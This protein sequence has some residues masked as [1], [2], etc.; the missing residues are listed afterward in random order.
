MKERRSRIALKKIAGIARSI[1][2]CRVSSKEQ[3]SNNSLVRQNASVYDEA[4]KLN[5]EIPNDDYVWS[6]SVSGKRGTNTR[7]RDLQEMIAFC[8]KDKSVKFLIIDEPDRFMR[9]IDEAFYFEIVF[10]EIGVKVWYMDPELNGDNLQSKMLRFMKYFGAESSNEE[11]I[12]KSVNGHIKALAE[13][14]YTFRTKPG[15]VKG[16]KADGRHEPHPVTW[17]YYKSALTRIAAGLSSVKETMDD[18]HQT[19]P[20]ILDRA[21][22]PYTFDEWKKLVTDP[23]YAGIVEMNKQVKFRNEN[24]LHKAMVTKAQHERILEIVNGVKKK[25]N[26]PRKGGNPKYPLNAVGVCDNCVNS[27]H[28]FKFTGSNHTNGKT[29][30]IYEDYRCRGCGRVIKRSDF[31]EKVEQRF[32]GIDMTDEGRKELMAALEF[33][34]AAEGEEMKREVARV[35]GRKKALEDDNTAHV[36]SLADP[37]V[38]SVRTNIVAAIERNNEE[39]KN[40]NGQLSGLDDTLAGEKKRFMEFALVFADQLGRQFLSLSLKNI[41]VCKQ[42]IFPAGFWVGKNLEV[43]TPEISPIY[44]FRNTIAGSSMTGKPAMVRGS[45]KSLHIIPMQDIILAYKKL[46]VA[47]EMRRWQEILAVPYNLYRAKSQEG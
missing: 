19:C 43:Y 33:I 37:A 34:W 16:P 23:Y 2:L 31:H 12:T 30:K 7:R 9:S 13:G 17:E 3:E 35:V 36:K 5:V 29:C 39:I 21:Q 18:F 27:G 25:Q 6:G 15:Y 26:G 42:I 45:S 11:R 32:G 46:D 1:A 10:R 41:E 24:G 44:R 38:A 8:K 4:T 28:V 14:R 22:K 20:V 47:E 40:L